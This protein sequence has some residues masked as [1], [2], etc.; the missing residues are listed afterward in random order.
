MI[1]K[2]NREIAKEILYRMIFN[3][4]HHNTVRKK[5]KFL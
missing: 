4:L 1:K 3:H 2:L 5:G